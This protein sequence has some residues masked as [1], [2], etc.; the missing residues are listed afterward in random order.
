[1]KFLSL[2]ALLTVSAVPAFAHT[3][4]K[5]T[6]VGGVSIS[7]L[8]QTEATRRLTRELA[9][10]LE[11][12][13]ALV[14][15]NK[16]V[17]RRRSDLGFSLDV[18]KMLA[19]AK[20][21]QVVPIAFRVDASVASGALKRLTPDLTTEVRD[22]VPIYVK[23]EVQIRPSI[24]GK[25]LDAS[26]SAARIKILAEK[27]PTRTRFDLAETATQP[28]VSS[29]DLKGI[30]SVI[31]SY[32]TRFNPGKI[33]RTENIRVAIRSIDGKVIPNG[34]TFS[35]N[36]AVGERTKARGYKD[37]IIFVDG[38]EEEGLGGG[39]SQVTGTLFNAA[40]EAGLPIVTYRTHSRPVVYISLGRDATVAW[41]N[42]DNK[43]KNDTG[44][45]IYIS[46][47][48]KGR[49]R[50]KATLFGKDL[51]RTTKI[52]VTSKR[53]GARDIRANLYRVIYKNGEV[54]TNEKVGSSHY[55]WKA[56]D[57]D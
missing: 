27:E 20:Q 46:Y 8:N 37:A 41:G 7:E 1:M 4:D 24:V 49:N 21:Q 33:G 57:E 43:W 13:L 36:N 9:P 56:D 11:S 28:K 29:D 15:G 3:Y 16:K 25:R 42:F 34:A 26:T 14:V 48:I 50:L 22:A 18:G 52:R 2:V 54:Q 39:V 44:A 51:G 30:N 23:D 12:K 53:N 17:Y 38:K 45:P 10:R 35:L 6:A 32:T 19:Q 31:G 40:L 5:G 55:K 47:Q